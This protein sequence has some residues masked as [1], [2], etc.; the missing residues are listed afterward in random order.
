MGYFFAKKRRFGAWAFLALIPALLLWFFVFK[1]P[2]SKFGLAGT[3]KAVAFSINGVDYGKIKTKADTVGDFLVEQ[4][5][6]LGEKDQVW[7]S[8]EKALYSGNVIALDRARKV[9]FFDRGQKIEGYVL[10]ATVEAA[11]E[12][13]NISVGEDDIVSPEL[14]EIAHHEEKIEIIRVEIKEEKETKKIEFKKV[15]EEDDDLG[16][17]VKKVSQAGKN[18]KKELTYKAV[19]HNGKLISRKLVDEKIIE[20][21]VSEISVQGTFVKLGKSHTGLGTW[22]AWKGGLFA[23]NP[24]LPMGS[25][26]KVTNL[27]NGK[28]VIVQINDRGP[29]GPNR[30]IDLDKVAFAKIASLGAGVINVKMEEIAN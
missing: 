27:D 5:I 23:A 4:K 17:R 30:I 9:S 15:V 11:I 16:W 20:E 19:Y 10:G 22:Y 29:F 7:P 2:E 13:N 12:E 8:E 6:A 21:P 1:K 25:Y 24:W 28:S 14:G 18:G 26:V 3:E